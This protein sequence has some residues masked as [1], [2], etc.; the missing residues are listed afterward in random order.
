M[1]DPKLTPQQLNALK[2]VSLAGGPITL[3]DLPRKV[4]L[5]TLKILCERGKLRITVEMAPDGLEA[6]AERERRLAIVLYQADM[7]QRLKEV[8]SPPV[9]PPEPEE[10]RLIRPLS[11]ADLMAGKAHTRAHHT[12]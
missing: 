2:A 3:A 9:K 5:S 12:G 11:K 10:E 1:P 6:L 4:T 7:K 8:K